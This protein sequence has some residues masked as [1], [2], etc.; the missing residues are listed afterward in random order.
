MTARIQPFARAAS[1]FVSALA[2]FLACAAFLPGCATGATVVGSIQDVT[3]Q[4]YGGMV[5]TLQFTPLSC[6]QRIGT[7]T[8][9]PIAKGVTLTNGLFQIQLAG[10]LYYVGL[11]GDSGPPSQ[12]RTLKIL[13]PPNDTN[14]WQFNDCANLA[15]NL[16]TFG[17][18][19]SLALIAATNINNATGTN[20]SL[21][22]TFNTAQYDVA[23]LAA[24]AQLAAQ[25]FAWNQFTN[26]ATSGSFY[27]NLQSSGNLPLAGV[28][29][30]TN[31]L[32]SVVT[33]NQSGVTLNN[34]ILGGV[35][36]SNQTTVIGSAHYSSG[37]TIWA[38]DYGDIIMT[39]GFTGGHLVL[40]AGQTGNVLINRDAP[41]GV[42]THIVNGNLIM[43]S[44]YYSGN[45]SGLTNATAYQIATTYGSVTTTSN[46]ILISSFIT[47]PSTNSLI[48]TNSAYI[49]ING[50]YTWSGT[51]YVN[52][53]S[54][55]C[56]T[57]T[58][59]A[60]FLQN[61][62]THANLY[63]ITNATFPTGTWN[64]TGTTTNPPVA[65]TLGTA[66]VTN[67]VAVTGGKYSGDGSLLVNLTPAVLLATNAPANGY[68]L[69]YT[70]GT[71][72]WAP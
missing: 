33:N 17:W 54:Q 46:S 68:A 26:A 65:V 23:G 19:N 51:Q 3:G 50:T 2:I 22:G 34:L 15:T 6:P 63:W 20:V 25:S 55:R 67:S 71:F 12:P 44:G 39:A 47:A 37:T 69:R 70:N 43:D 28:L 60:W 1:H 32:A 35:L 10:G 53:N 9:W 16:G 18:T 45:A 49:Y 41:N 66:Q 7:N 30:L 59:S 64:I 4:P 29:G 21:T 42:D 61:I 58:G 27:F 8:V 5:N 48:V 14:L 11:L 24:T 38:G 40:N 13:V 56:I 57:N 36:N 52:A 62:F 31:W 72:Y